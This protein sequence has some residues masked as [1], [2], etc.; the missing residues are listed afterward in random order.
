MN[1]PTLALLETRLHRVERQN[2]L[3]LALLYALLGLTLL[4]A[5]K[6]GGN[7]I[8]VDEIRTHRLSL[9]N[10]KG[11]VVHNWAVHGGWVIEK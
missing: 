4:G 1:T 9:I 6:G 11:D 7:V 3:L 10:D 8:T 5:T 2:R